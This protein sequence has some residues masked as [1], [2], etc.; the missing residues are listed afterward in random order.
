MILLSSKDQG[1][2]CDWHLKILSGA[3]DED[4]RTSIVVDAKREFFLKQNYYQIFK[5]LLIRVNF[6]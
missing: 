2:E 4:G 3:A 5:V 6:G 1:E